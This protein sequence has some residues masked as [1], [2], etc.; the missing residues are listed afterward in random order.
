[1][2]PSN[3]KPWA[4]K[5]FFA[6]LAVVAGG[7]VAL[8]AAMVLA[9]VAYVADAVEHPDSANPF[10]QALQDAEIRYSIH[11]TLVSCSIVAVLS[12]LVAVPVGYLLSRGQ[13]VGKALLDTLLDIPLVLPPLVVGISLLI[14][15]QFLPPGLRDAVVYQT[16]GVILAQFV[17]A[18]A[19]AIR[20]MKVTFDQIDRRREEVAQTL[21]ASRM[22][23]L[24]WVTL[25]E[26]APGIVTAG[27]LAWARSL[28]EF[29]PLLVFAGATR[30]KTEVLATTV[31]LEMSVGN[32]R[33]AVAV[34]L[35]MIAT[36][37]VVLTITRLTIG[38]RLTA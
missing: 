16:P 23:A 32:L 7:Y 25:P 9:D 10:V 24:G 2:S 14:L 15:F 21:G 20:T 35:L 27:M 5:L 3:D 29:G 38:R 33:G 17:V 11:L 30:G 34:S 37:V 13:F 19:L 8:L 22:Q 28:G 36:A 12:L 4:D 6:V 18:A 26:A 31:F 1:M